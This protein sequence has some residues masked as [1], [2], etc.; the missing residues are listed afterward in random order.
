MGVC[1]IS[2]AG[3]ESEQ[4]KPS[5]HLVSW[6]T[7]CS[8]EETW[9]AREY[10]NNRSKTRVASIVIALY[11]MSQ[12]RNTKI[13]LKSTHQILEI[14]TAIDYFFI[15]EYWRILSKKL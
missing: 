3:N 5:S 10:K 9:F 8:M 6:V 2:K 4:E 15:K 13:K 14:I 11:Q 1:G 7:I 12:H